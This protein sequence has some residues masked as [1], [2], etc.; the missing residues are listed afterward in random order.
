MDK[1]FYWSYMINLSGHMWGDETTKASGWYLS[2]SYKETNDVDI[3]VC[4]DLINEVCEAFGY[5]ELFHIGFD[6]EGVENQKG[7]EMIN[8]VGL[9]G[10]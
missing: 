1:K 10:I 6:E 5:P 7:F 2:S 4:S 8:R 3:E 9:C